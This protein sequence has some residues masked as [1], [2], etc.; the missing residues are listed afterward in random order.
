MCS[1]LMKCLWTCIRDLWINRSFYQLKRNYM[2]D[3]FT[4]EGFVS[5]I[6]IFF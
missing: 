2:T 3:S 4:V 5:V 1:S 6:M